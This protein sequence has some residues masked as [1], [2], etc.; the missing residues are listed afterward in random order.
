MQWEDELW[1]LAADRY[2]E[3]LF[4]VLENSFLKRR[5]SVFGRDRFGPQTESIPWS[6]G[7]LSLVGVKGLFVDVIS[8]FS[9]IL[10]LIAIGR[11]TVPDAR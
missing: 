11:R 3:G 7:S 8:A 2:G 9:R 4:G 6:D 5:I 1:Q 10:G